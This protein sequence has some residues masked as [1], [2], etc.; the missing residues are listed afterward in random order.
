VD[1]LPRFAKLSQGD[2]F[3]VRKSKGTAKFIV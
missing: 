2:E 1:N 3:F